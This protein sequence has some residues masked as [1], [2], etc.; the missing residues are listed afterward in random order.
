MLDVTQSLYYKRI[1]KLAF[2]QVVSFF[3]LVIVFAIPQM[4]LLFF[5]YIPELLAPI[6]Q[7]LR[8]SD[9]FQFKMA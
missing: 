7:S 1:A 4:L 6:Q 2:W 3:I 8:R 9:L 5:K